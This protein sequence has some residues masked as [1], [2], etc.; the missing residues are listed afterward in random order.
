MKHFKSQ[1]FSGKFVKYYEIFFSDKCFSRIGDYLLRLFKECVIGDRILDFGCGTGIFCEYFAKNGYKVVGVD[2]SFDMIEYAKKNH[3][4][5]SARGG[6]QIE[7]YCD[8]IRS[9]PR[10]NRKKFENFNIVCALSHVICYQVS[11]ESLLK[12]FSNAYSNLEYNGIFVFDF[13]HQAGIFTHNLNA[14]I[15][16]V[17][18]GEIKIVRFSEAEFDLME[19]SIN[20]SYAYLICDGSQKP[21]FLESNDTMRFFSTKELEFYLKNVGFRSIEFFDLDDFC[22][23]QLTSQR[24]NGY[25]VARK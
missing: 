4:L 7:Y 14:R 6:G 2:V 12:V 18:D 11:N 1:T 24:Q 17:A 15:K 8:D 25:C 19:N 21:L 3:N 23:V 16:K 13:Y 22:K 5:H 9:F 10:E 20:V